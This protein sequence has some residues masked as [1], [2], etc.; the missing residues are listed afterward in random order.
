MQLT[1]GL[2]FRL[3]AGR[4]GNPQSDAGADTYADVVAD[5]PTDAPRDNLADVE[6]DVSTACE[7]LQAIGVS[8]ELIDGK[9]VVIEGCGFGTKPQAAPIFFDTVDQV[10][11]NGKLLSPHP[12]DAIADGDDVPVGGSNPWYVKNEGH[13]F[14]DRTGPFYGVRQSQY[15]V[16]MQYHDGWLEGPNGFPDT[17]SNE[18]KAVYVRWYMKPSFNPSTDWADYRPWFPGLGY[19]YLSPNEFLATGGDWTDLLHEGRNVRIRGDLTG[20]LECDI[21]ESSFNGSDTVVRVG[22][23]TGFSCGIIE[24]E[25]IEVELEQYGY[26]TFLGPWIRLETRAWG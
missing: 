20:W 2:R 25:A 8:G 26:S 6:E 11:I 9:P 3:R 16:R 1:V 5:H 15:R 13:V 22:E 17:Q 18:V 23:Q 12:Y 14:I 24:N 10:W 21:K 4:A 19:A 7:G